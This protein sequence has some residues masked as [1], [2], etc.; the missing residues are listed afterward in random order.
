MKQEKL[1]PTDMFSS[2]DRAKQG[3]STQRKLEGCRIC[4]QNN[5]TKIRILEKKQGDL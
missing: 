4:D 5:R 3:N 2:V 1:I